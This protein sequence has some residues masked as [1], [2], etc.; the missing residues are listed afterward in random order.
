MP[1]DMHYHDFK[2]VYVDKSLTLKAWQESH[3]RNLGSLNRRISN[4]GAF[5]HLKIPMQKKAVV[6]ICRKYGVDISGLK[7]KIQRGEDCLKV[8]IAGATDYFDIGRIDLLPNAFK[9]TEQL[10][11]TV[12]HEGC[13]VRQLKKYGREYVQNNVIYMERVAKRYE[14]FFYRRKGGSLY[15]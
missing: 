3:S 4:S 6:Q 9:D 8:D 13:H 12:I 10:L 14:D 1:A 7:I 15:E 5:A 11:R 2:R